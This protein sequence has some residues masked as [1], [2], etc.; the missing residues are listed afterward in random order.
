MLQL[1]SDIIRKYPIGN[2]LDVDCSGFKG[3]Y[4]E[5][6]LR[7]FDQLHELDDDAYNGN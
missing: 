7:L 3:R 6:T 5:Q 1:Q 4:G 2:A